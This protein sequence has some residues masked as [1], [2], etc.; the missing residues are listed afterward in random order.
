VTDGHAV[1]T[2][3]ST[4]GTVLCGEASLMMKVG[5][6]DLDSLCLG[7]AE[8]WDEKMHQHVQCLY[9]ATAW[10]HL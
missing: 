8:F 3:I 7:H 6:V 2:G 4:W 9:L 10:Q 5:V 1:Q